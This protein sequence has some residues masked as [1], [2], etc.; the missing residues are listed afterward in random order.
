MRSACRITAYAALTGLLAFGRADAKA[1]QPEHAEAAI[2]IQGLVHQL[3]GTTLMWCGG[4]KTAPR[5]W[6][7]VRFELPDQPLDQHLGLEG[8]GLIITNVCKDSP[9][10]WAGLLRYDVLLSFDERELDKGGKGLAAKIHEL[11][12]DADVAIV[13]LRKA[14][15]LDLVAK[16][17]TFPAPGKLEWIYQD[18]PHVLAEDSITYSLRVIERGPGGD[19]KIERLSQDKLPKEFLHILGLAGPRTLKVW[20][21]DGETKVTCRMIKD[22]VVIEVEQDS[23]GRVHVRRI[24]NEEEAAAVEEEIYVDEESLAKEDLA[25]FELFKSCRPHRVFG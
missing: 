5:A 7:G 24:A 8:R 23:E 17:S 19:M 15:K 6:F 10:Y 13:V 18:A 16:L 22:G 21:E 2:T 12:A 11:G 9:A 25:A 4:D 14:K 1:P 3:L 20:N